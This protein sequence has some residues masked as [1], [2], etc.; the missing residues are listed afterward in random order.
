M[1]I[2]I[3]NQTFYPDVVSTAQHAADLAFALAGQGHEVTVLA[4]RRGY[5]TPTTLFPRR[6]QW[7]GVNIVRIDST[8]LG[9]SAKWRRA[10]DFASFIANAGFHMLRLSHFDVIVAMT[11]PP[12]ISFLAA[13]ASPLKADKLVFWCM[14][15]N[16]DEAIAAGWLKEASLTSRSLAR[17]LLY[18]LKRADRIVALDR[19]MKKRIESKGIPAQK[20]EVIPPWAQDDR[21]RFDPDGR[22]AFRARH[23][24][25]DKFVVMY[26]GNHSPCH[27]LDTV[28]KAAE[29]LSHRSEL[30]FCF[31]GGGSEF[32]RVKDYARERALNNIVCL[33]YQPIEKLAASLSGADLHLVVMG[34]PFVGI[35]HP[36]KIY[37]V[38]AANRRFLYIG[39]RESSITDLISHLSIDGKVG[40]A[41]H[42]D[43]EGTVE[44]I[45]RA[46]MTD[47]SDSSFA[48]DIASAFSQDALVRRMVA[49]V[50]Q[51]ALDQSTVA[52]GELEPAV[53]ADKIA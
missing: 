43:V 42:G 7:K 47:S 17:A 31:I 3:L 27:P 34:E 8:G 15:L 52:E 39:P 25:S 30:V 18:S 50:T 44:Q 20:V 4:S 26:S 19:F 23:G 48:S 2:L 51:E 37:N 46:L 11:S 33:P 49:A 35:V 28:L 14:D 13:L 29:Q 12:L 41:S 1:K 10:V 21:V 45:E 40:Q 5:D 24:L 38:L 16:P 36:C 6:E 9:K 22:N 32:R 53:R